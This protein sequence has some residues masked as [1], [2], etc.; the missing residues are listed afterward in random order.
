MISDTSKDYTGRDLET[1]KLSAWRD[2]TA[3]KRES[4]EYWRDL[5][6]SEQHL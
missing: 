4:K 1:E 5:S 2:K 3:I 6:N